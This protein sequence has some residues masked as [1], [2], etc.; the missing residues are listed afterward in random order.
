MKT[1]LIAGFIVFIA[2][3]FF[4]PN[5]YDRYTVKEKG[6][7]VKMRIEKLPASC[8]G[9]K[10]PYFVTFSFEGEFFD[11]QTRGDFCD[12]HHVGELVDIQYLEGAKH[13]LFS[14]E[15]ALFDLLSCGILSLFGM[16]LIISQWKKIKYE[17]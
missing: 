10:V 12:K 17:K 4:I 8:I 1:L 7:L 15:P 6:H 5:S 9:S 11:K 14:E 3:L 13:I 16:F 2:P